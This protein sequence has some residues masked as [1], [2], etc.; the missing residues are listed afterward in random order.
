MRAMSRVGQAEKCESHPPSVF[1]LP[2]ECHTLFS[3]HGSCFLVAL[4]TRGEGQRGEREGEFSLVL[5]H[6]AE[7]DTFLAE[8]AG[9]RVV[10]LLPS[11]CT[12][13]SQRLRMQVRWLDP[14]C[15]PH[16]ALAQVTRPDPEPC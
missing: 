13:P 10:T 11:E 7:R 6:S 16:A 3:K 15:E 14:F 5:Q 4:L 9:Y 1:Q 12:R 2:V 8:S